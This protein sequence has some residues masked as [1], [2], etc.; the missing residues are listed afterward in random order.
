MKF[1]TEI[2]VPSIG[3]TIDHDTP[4]VMLGSCFTDEVGERLRRELFDVTVNPLGTLFN[5]IS[6][7]DAITDVIDGREFNDDELFEVDGTW[8]TLRRHSRFALTDRNATLRLLNES[9]A[10]THNKLLS[11]KLLIVTFGSAMAH[12]HI[13]TATIAANC[14]KL[15]SGQFSVRPIDDGEIMTKWHPLLERLHRL[16]PQL[17]V[18]FTVSPVR[19]I[20]YGLQRDRLSKSILLVA[21]NRLVG[22]FTH[23][24][25]SYEIMV[26]D[27]RDYRWYADDMVHPSSVAVDYIY[28]IFRQSTMSPATTLAA[29]KWRKLTLRLAHRHTSADA[30]EKFRNETIGMASALAAGNTKLFQRFTS[31][32]NR[33]D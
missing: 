11:A 21:A 28:D 6:I 3:I 20:G 33:C 7:A 29:D 31:Y 32:I 12:Y 27:L 15:P 14:H 9:I 1:R 18:I 23:Y 8:R 19:H 13:P 30:A 10:A 2:K 25:P 22:D 4:I 16:N 26:D 5:P 24:F 17:H